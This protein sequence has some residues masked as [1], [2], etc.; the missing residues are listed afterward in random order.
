MSEKI[1]LKFATL[2]DCGDLVPH[3]KSEDDSGFDLKSKV[4][5]ILNPGQIQV[6]ACGFKMSVPVG[7]EGQVRPRSGLAAKFG[8]GVLNSPGTID[9]G[10]RGEVCV[11]LV[12]HSTAPYTIHRGDRIAQLVINKLPPVEVELVSES[13]LSQTERGE[14]GFGSSGVN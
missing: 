14:K 12:N 7:Y 4:D 5:T 6:V 8:I 9:S 3:R 13:D 10:Y 11:I 2:E 1:K